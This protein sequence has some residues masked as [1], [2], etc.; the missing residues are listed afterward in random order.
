M[1]IGNKLKKSRLESKLTQEKVAEEIQVS[2]QTISNWEN[3][4]SYPDIIS[5]IKLSDLYN[6]SL[7]ELLKGDSEMI[8]HLEESTNIVSSNKKLLI[9]FGIN[10]IF[11]ILFIFFNG[12]ISS[13]NY[14]IIGAASIG[15]LSISALF[16]QIIKK[17]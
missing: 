1:E 2:R 5:V 6:V 9:A 7:D 3:E 16:Y 12:V 13:N 11:F 10:I 14:L 8:K 4:K 17:F 15:V